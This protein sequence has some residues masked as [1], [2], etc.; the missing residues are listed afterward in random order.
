MPQSGTEQLLE[1]RAR[2][3]G[4]P[5]HRG[6]E[7]VGLTQDGDQVRLELQGPDGPAAR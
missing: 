7:L 2:E 4:V 1:E 6:A 3:L 5:I